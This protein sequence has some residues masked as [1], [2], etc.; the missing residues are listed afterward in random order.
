MKKAK[1]ELDKDAIKLIAKNLLNSD[2]VEELILEAYEDKTGVWLQF[3]TEER[4]NFLKEI[5][6]EV[7][8]EILRELIS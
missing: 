3:D 1:Q 4:N 7:C 8:L 2:T 6:K 5:K